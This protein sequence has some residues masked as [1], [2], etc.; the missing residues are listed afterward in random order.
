MLMVST[1]TQTPLYSP[2]AKAFP[3]QKITQATTQARAKMVHRLLF[4]FIWGPPTARTFFIPGSRGDFHNNR[5]KFRP[6]S[7]FTLEKGT[8]GSRAVYLG[9]PE[10]SENLQKAA[11]GLRTPHADK[12]LT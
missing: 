4:F 5:I 1:P 8:A 9:K 7:H 2:T 10:L 12:S 6:N 3:D 11:C